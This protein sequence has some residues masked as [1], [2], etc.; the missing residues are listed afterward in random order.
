MYDV[1]EHADSSGAR[2]LSWPWIVGGGAFLGLVGGGASLG[3]G[4]IV[5]LLYGT[6]PL[7]MITCYLTFP[8]LERP[9]TS[10]SAEWLAFG[11]VLYL[12]TCAVFGVVYHWLV[13]RHLNRASYAQQFLLTGGIGV[14]LWLMNYYVILYGLQSA[15]QPMPWIA[16]YLPIGIAAA[17]HLSFVWTMLLAEWVREFYGR[18][19]EAS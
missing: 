10:L 7:W 12:L 1:K 4:L 8:W 14:G 17:A 15:F 16:A 2:T 11:C 18:R 9:S 19:V 3:V 6:E 5:S 13:I